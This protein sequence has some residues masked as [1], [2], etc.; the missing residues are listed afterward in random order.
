MN[1]RA[2]FTA[3]IRMMQQRIDE[4][5][6]SAMSKQ[7]TGA[8][9][10]ELLRLDTALGLYDEKLKHIKREILIEQVG[11]TP[12]SLQADMSSPSTGSHCIPFHKGENPAMPSTFTDCTCQHGI[13][14]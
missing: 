14:Y 7:S 2:A 6:S 5:L 3:L 9:Q 11:A 13:N 4:E 10:R 12:F 1:T 8:T